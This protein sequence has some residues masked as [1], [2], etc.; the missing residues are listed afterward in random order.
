MTPVTSLLLG[1]AFPFLACQNADAVR[2]CEREREKRGG[3]VGGF[4]IH[5]FLS[6]D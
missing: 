1:V 5:D 3:G 4:C 6:K 2:I